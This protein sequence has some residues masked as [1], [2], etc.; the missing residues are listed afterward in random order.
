MRFT[1]L[2]VPVIMLMTG[3]SVYKRQAIE[4]PGPL[5]ET[6][7]EESP[8]DEPEIPIEEWWKIFNDERLNGLI[9][10]AFSKNLDL[11]EAIARLEQ[12]MAISRRTAA[13]QRPFIKLEGQASQD[14][15]PGFFGNNSGTSYRLSLSAGYELDLWQKLKS[16]TAAANLEMESS[17]QE[18]MALYLGLT[19]QI[20]DFYYLATEQRAQLDLTDST[21]DSF[22]DTLKRVDRR[23]RAGLVSALDVY[24]ARQN[25]ASARARR[26]IFEANL[27]LAEHAL[28]VLLGRYPQ[29]ET[30][31]SSAELP[32]EFAPL[33]AGLPSELLTRRPDIQAALLR[34]RASDEM[35]AAAIADRFPSIN[36]L[37]SYGTSRTAFSTGDLSGA[38][39]SLLVNLAQPVLDGGSRSAEVD[40]S[41]AVFRENLAR[42]H[43]AV[44][45]A[46]QEVEDSLARS[47]AT[48]QRI[49]MLQDRV[50]AASNA[51]RLSL[52]RYMFGLSDYLPV[53]TAQILLFDAQ[54]ALLEG[55]RQLIS[56]RV[57]LARAIGGDWMY[58][59]V[60]ERL[61][62]DKKKKETKG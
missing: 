50:D 21:I 34:L 62:D 61:S 58:E 27:A 39:W 4:L 31:G 59:A 22:V 9:D 1:I 12:S 20:V 54:S 2:L 23:Y 60:E 44:L 19:A 30:V 3:C 13:A 26:K 37:G 55:R 24:Q 33:S 43:R 56:D 5:P 45:S 53:L 42:Y 38:F 47:S 14:D 18:V 52:D 51:L 7:V 29:R 6:F 40:R 28:T 15:A 49:R 35:V 16:R 41:R 10:E 8:H 46:F 57:S 25:L 36:I 11:A 32:E 48:E 17:R